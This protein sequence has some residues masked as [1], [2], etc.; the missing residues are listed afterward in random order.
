MNDIAFVKSQLQLEK[1]AGMIEGR[2][3]SGL[4]VTDWC[5]ENG[6][7]TKTYY[8]RQR[9]VRQAALEKLSDEDQPIFGRLQVSPQQTES[10]AAVTV[11]LPYA[12]VQITEAASER[13]ITAVMAALKKTC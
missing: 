5:R 12:T 1:W 9:K 2:K 7:C 10:L 4:T 13:T 11:H 6:I 8:Y 3:A